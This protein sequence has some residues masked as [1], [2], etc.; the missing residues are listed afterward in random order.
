MWGVGPALL[1]PTATDALLGSEKLAIG[2]A[3]VILL[4]K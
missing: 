2:L 1:L 3:F 4:P